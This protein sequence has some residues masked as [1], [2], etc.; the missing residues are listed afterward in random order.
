MKTRPRHHRDAPKHHP[1][2]A[3]PRP[4]HHGPR[5]QRDMA[6]SMNFSILKHH[7]STYAAQLHWFAQKGAQYSNSNWNFRFCL[8][9]R[10]KCLSR[11]ITKKS[12]HH[13]QNKKKQHSNINGTTP[14]HHPLIIKISQ[15]HHHTSRNL[16]RYMPET[17]PTH[18]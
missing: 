10:S 6:E 15:H 9:T 8:E 18:Y 17:L 1:S 5:Y 2:N 11:F 7:P 3:K 4:T 16:Y 13:Y 12:K 14:N